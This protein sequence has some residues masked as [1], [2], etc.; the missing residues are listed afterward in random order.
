MIDAF[1]ELTEILIK[2]TTK[3]AIGYQKIRQFSELV[4]SCRIYE[5][6]T[7]AHYKVMSERRGKSQQSRPKP[8]NAPADKGKQRV[9]ERRPRRKD[10]PTEIVCYKCNGK[11]H[12][13]NACPED[14]KRCFRCGKKG[15]T[16]TECKRGDMVCFNCDEEGNISSQ[17]KQPM[18]AQTSGR[19]F[20][21]TGT[22]T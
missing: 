8:Y 17:C 13:S 1:A 15:H 5:E 16:I 18:K 7:K 10:T 14:D 11:G 9:D 3:R 19:V 21:L 4:S 22:Q 20:A 6:D 2:N 12:K